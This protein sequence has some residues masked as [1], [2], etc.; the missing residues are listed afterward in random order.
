MQHHENLKKES[1]YG[2][3]AA[4]QTLDMRLLKI[5]RTINL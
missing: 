4:D 2:L 3:P 5:K 1:R